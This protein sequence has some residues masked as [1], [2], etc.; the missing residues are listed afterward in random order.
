MKAANAEALA[1]AAAKCEAGDLSDEDKAAV[2][3]ARRVNKLS[4]FIH[5]ILI[6]QSCI[7]VVPLLL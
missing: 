5:I 3:D 7:N 1:G 4:L 6:D 2:L